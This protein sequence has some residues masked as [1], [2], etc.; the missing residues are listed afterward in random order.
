MLFSVIIYLNFNKQ[1]IIWQ[2]THE[3]RMAAK[4]KGFAVNL[5][6][7]QQISAVIVPF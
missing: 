4:L 2:T 7:S 5:S 3:K 6:K 1:Q